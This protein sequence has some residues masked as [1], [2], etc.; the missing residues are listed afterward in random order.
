[1]GEARV[2]E[3]RGRLGAGGRERGVLEVT[4][5][6]SW[7][8]LGVDRWRRRRGGKRANNSTRQL[9]PPCPPSLTAPS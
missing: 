7:L 3:G 5:A 2:R 8:L 6:M 9:V 1:M 4:K